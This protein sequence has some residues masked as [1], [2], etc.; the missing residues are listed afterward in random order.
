MKFAGLEIRPR[1]I[2]KVL[3]SV[4]KINWIF[5]INSRKNCALKGKSRK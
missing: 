2:I 1:N 4:K 3:P 5:D